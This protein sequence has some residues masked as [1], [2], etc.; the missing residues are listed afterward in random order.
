[1]VKREAEKELIE[2][3]RQFKAVAL[4]GP[5]QSGKTTLARN[6]FAH[7]PYVNLENLDTRNFALNDPRGFL[8]QYSSGAILD[9][10]QRTPELFAYL[11]QILDES[12]ETG[13]FIIT[14]SNNFLLQE[15]ISQSLA[16][17][18]AY[19]YLLPFTIEEAG[20]SNNIDNVLHKGLY[21]PIYDQNIEPS[22]WHANY[23]RTYVERDVRQIKNISNLNV[24]EK[25]L[26]LCAGRVGQLLNMNSLAI[27]AGVDGKT[28][29]SWINV[30]ESS[31]II[32][33]L[34]PHHASFNK[35]VVKMPKLYFYDTGLACSLLGISSPSQLSTHYAKGSLFEN[36]VITELVKFR[37]NRGDNHNLFFWRDNIGHEVDLLVE[38]PKGLFPIEIKAGSTIR[39]NFF[40]GVEYWNKLAGNTRGVVVYTGDS[41]QERSS[42]ISI[43]PWL[44]INNIYD[45]V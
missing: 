24:F 36:F 39:D 6:V 8:K 37:Y 10:A 33:R 44:S 13:R 7:L 14:G 18:I 4:V 11:Q 2:L 19:L 1:M 22:K 9:E 3:S 25:F 38:T 16:G 27:E 28:I 34:Q 45:L 21:P 35:R 41:K 17:R 20:S 12:S 23:I 43:L 15:N 30:L 5:R 32:Y 40:E 31:F 26:R 29:A 42:G